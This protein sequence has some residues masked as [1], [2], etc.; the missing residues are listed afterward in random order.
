MK[1]LVTFVRRNILSDENFTQCWNFKFM[2]KTKEEKTDLP[3]LLKLVFWQNKHSLKSHSSIDIVY[4][5]F[6]GFLLTVGSTTSLSSQSDFDDS[7]IFGGVLLTLGVTTSLSSSL[8]SWN[9]FQRLRFHLFVLLP[10]NYTSTN[11]SWSL[12]FSDVLK[13]WGF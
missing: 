9:E 10:R 5:P 7:Q 8:L 13:N 2:F 12:S 4:N 11:L 3:N 6:G 1:N